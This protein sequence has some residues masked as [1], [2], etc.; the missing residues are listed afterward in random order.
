MTK[1]DNTTPLPETCIL[2]VFLPKYSHWVLY[3]KG[4]YYDPEFGLMDELYCK[5]R[6]QSYLEIFLGELLVIFVVKD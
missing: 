6:V 5:A 2:K 4:K 1:A 3:H